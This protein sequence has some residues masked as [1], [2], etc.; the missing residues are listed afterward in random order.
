MMAPSYRSWED[1]GVLLFRTVA[2]W[3]VQ[4]TPELGVLLPHDT[5]TSLTARED[6]YGY[7]LA[8]C[9]GLPVVPLPGAILAP[10]E[11]QEV[12]ASGV[13][14]LRSRA[15]RMS[16]SESNGGGDFYARVYEADRP[17]L[18]FK[19]TAH[20]VVGDTSQTRAACASSTTSA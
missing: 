7:L 10:I 15:A 9:K 2:G 11:E 8:A 18:F 3:W 19:S 20:R 12:W 5:A 17:E 6:L 14:Y 13:T 1:R 4:T 16:E